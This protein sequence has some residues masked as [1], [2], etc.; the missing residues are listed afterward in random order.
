M[1]NLFINLLFALLIALF[2]IPASFAQTKP[3]PKATPK[4]AVKTNPEQTVPET[5][6]QLFAKAKNTAAAA[7]RTKNLQAFMEK[8]PESQFKVR[9]QELM[10]SSRAQSADEKIQAGDI[11]AG[12][13]LFELAVQEAPTPVSEGLFTQVLSLIPENLAVRN[14]YEA[15]V[16]V[17]GLVE[18]KIGNNVD[19]LLDLAKFHLGI[20]NFD[21]AKR[22]AKKIIELDPTKPDAYE[23]LGSASVTNLE[24][25][26]AADAYE[27]ALSLN[28]TSVFIKLYLANIKRALGRSD[29]ATALYGQILEKEPQNSLARTGK[30]LSLFDAGKRQEA[31]AQMGEAIA[32]NPKNYNL[33][34]GA[35]YWYAAHNEGDKAVDLA[36]RAIAIEPRYVWSHIALARG[37]LLQKNPVD[38]ERAMLQASQY[39]NF[40]TVSYERANAKYAVGFFEEAAGDLRRIFTIKDGKLEVKLAG[41]IPQSGDSFIDILERERR[42]SIYE[43]AAAD[44]PENA[45]KLKR[46]LLFDAKLNEPEAKEADIAAAAEAFIGENDPMRSFRQL[47]A[48]NKLLRKKLLPAKVLEFAQ[49][50]V[51]GLDTSVAVPNATLAVLAEELLEPRASALTRGTTVDV[52][53]IPRPV[54][55]N[56]MR[57]RI[58]EIA[59][60]TMFQ[61]E[62]PDEALVRLR[63]AVS[64]LPENSAWWRSSLWKLAT[65]LD[66]TGKPEEAFGVYAKSYLD[67]QPDK[68]KYAT[69]QG[70]CQR[71]YGA[72]EGCDEKMAAAAKGETGVKKAVNSVLKTPP[73]PLP[74]PETVTKT[75]NDPPSNETKEAEPI[76]T[77]SPTALSISDSTLDTKPSPVL[78]AT[79]TPE[80]VK[81]VSP[82]SVETPKQEPSPGPE[83]V[84]K[85]DGQGRKRTVAP[86]TDGVAGSD[87]GVVYSNSAAQVRVG[88]LSSNGSSGCQ[89]DINPQKLN[90][91][92][93]GG[94]GS[95]TI[96]LKGDGKLE[97]IK[98]SAENL[99]DLSLELQA[100]IGKDIGR[101]M[102]VVR[103][104]STKKGEFKLFVESAC[105]EKKEIVV[106]VR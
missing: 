101:V 56:I 102:Y 95:I 13:A 78:A 47:Y 73:A 3:K 74:T 42:A 60:W 106:T 20:D 94:W 31:E 89:I 81:P 65:V 71:L 79:S 76:P 80:P 96:D 91:I 82:I 21:D 14:Q 103:S 45:A 69:L 7:E 38:A 50:A 62:K 35:A 64:V 97:D 1:K 34:A 11:P 18:V 72:L 88:S 92:S 49:S 39:G 51:T 52:A 44:S 4:P 67:G 75:A 85:N 41:R 87:K 17:A 90:L 61:Q 5:E 83:T 99:E 77:P 8:F 100:G 43:P 84:A 23:V 12:I 24:L 25:P 15:A 27:K 33:L 98:V 55:T 58:E 53:A 63:R 57:G 36:R 104:I 68:I 32:A 86:K 46:L 22:L 30:V 48:A 10:V 37:L 59:G 66:A 40:P 2:T 54:L 93:N 9:V 29:E 105:G 26:E 16:K 28:N 6:E 70:L 19:Q